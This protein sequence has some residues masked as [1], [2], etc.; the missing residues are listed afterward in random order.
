MFLG[1]TKLAWTNRILSLIAFYLFCFFYFY[2]HNNVTH[3][4]LENSADHNFTMTQ[5]AV[6][7]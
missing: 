3:M 1:S 7:N 4:Y 2:I 6:E 5:C